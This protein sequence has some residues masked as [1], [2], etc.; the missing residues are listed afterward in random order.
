MTQGPTRNHLLRNFVSFPK[1]INSV[2]EL[3]ITAAI[4]MLFVSTEMDLD[5]NS[6]MAAYKKMIV[7]YLSLVY[8]HA[9]FHCYKKMTS[10]IPTQSMQCRARGWGVGHDT[11]MTY[12]CIRKS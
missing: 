1:L 5:Q 11:C 8:Y 6:I 2:L 9:S 3:H 12:L 4:T 10:D 7:E